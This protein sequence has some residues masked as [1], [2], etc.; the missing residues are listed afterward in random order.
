MRRSQTFNPKH[1]HNIDVLQ[2]FEKTNRILCT[3]QMIA[4]AERYPIPPED[5]KTLITA[6]EW[7]RAFMTKKVRKLKGKVEPVCPFVPPALDQ[8]LL[9]FSVAKPA[10]SDS[11]EAIYR[12][13]KLYHEIFQSFGPQKPPM[14]LLKALVVI[15]PETPGDVILATVNPERT[16]LKTELLENDIMIGEFFPACPLQASWDPT[17]F[18]LQSPIP[19]YALRSFVETDW[20]F[21]QGVREWRNIY[22]RRFG[23]PPQGDQHKMPRRLVRFLT[24]AAK[25][26]FRCH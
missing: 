11:I 4:D 14:S 2:I 17:F 20:R 24:K 26:R 1:P 8:Q 7:V 19:F 25:G 13:T 22:K 5:L 12:E 23:E 21:V 9:F 16:R 18:P 10:Q 3:P 15:F 6:E